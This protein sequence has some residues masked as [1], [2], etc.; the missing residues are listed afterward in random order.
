MARLIRDWTDSDRVH[1]LSAEAER[2]FTRLIMKADDYG[3]YVA[4]I[5]LLRASLFPL[6]ERLKDEKVE[7]W[8]K[9]CERADLILVYEVEN[10][11]YLEIK[12]FNQ[13]LKYRKSKYPP[14]NQ[15]DRLALQEGYVYLIGTDYKKPIKIGFSVNPWSRLKEITANH[16]EKLEILLTIRTDKTCESSLHK[17]LRKLRIKNEWFILTPDIIDCLIRF[18]KDEITKEMAIVEIRSISYLLR[19]PEIEVETE[20][21]KKLKNKRTNV[22]VVASDNGKPS[23]DEMKQSYKDLVKSIT[24]SDTKTVWIGL[25][26]FI[27]DKKPEFIEPYFEAWNI[28]AANLHLAKVETISESRKKKFKT[29]I[30]EISFDFIKILAKIKASQYLKGDNQANWKVSFDWIFENENN[31]IKILEGNYD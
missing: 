6:Y 13:T 30:Q 12:M 16:P 23:I 24:G 28:F 1:L 31:Y 17:E 29:R 27:S 2:F 19:S 9:E 11:R 14:S 10:K 8:L 7:S 5:K 4:N 18:S 3:R 22:L 21:E 20:V 25:S 26:H 15:D